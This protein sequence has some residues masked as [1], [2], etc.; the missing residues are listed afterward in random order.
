MLS[1]HTSSSDKSG[2][3]NCYLP[4]NHKK[5]EKSSK[6]PPTWNPPA[7]T[8]APSIE[9]GPQSSIFATCAPP[10]AKDG[11]PRFNNHDHVQRYRTIVLGYLSNSRIFVALRSSRRINTL[12]SISISDNIWTFLRCNT[13]VSVSILPPRKSH[14]NIQ[15]MLPP[16]PTFF[17][18]R[19]NYRY[20]IFNCDNIMFPPL[21]TSKT[22][23]CSLVRRI[24]TH[25]SYCPASRVIWNV[26]TEKRDD[27]I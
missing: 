26:V 13:E 15:P 23:Y 7:S 11:P 4:R 25:A 3:P 6:A 12:F 1:Y 21:R 8:M 9:S 10:I 27:K 24:L 5:P 14:L 20:A 2:V 18:W 16:P 22:T 19:Y 17:L